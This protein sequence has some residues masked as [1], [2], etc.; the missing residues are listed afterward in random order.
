MAIDGIIGHTGFVGSCLTAHHRFAGQFN[1]RNISESADVAFE[2]VVCA[3]A[4]GSMFDANNTPERDHAQIMQLCDRLSAIKTKRFVLISSIAVLENFAG[5]DDE[6]THN[7]QKNLAYGRHRRMLE[8]FCDDH[9]KDVLILRLPA[10][11]GSGL[12][13]NFLFDLLNPVPTMF[14]STKMNDALNSVAARDTDVLRQVYRLNPENNMFVL[15]R[16]ALLNSGAQSR[17]TDALDQNSLNAV[18]FTHPETTF[19]FYGVDRLWQDIETARTNGLRVLHLATEPVHASVIHHRV[20]GR[21]M[22]NTNAPLHHEDMRS[23]YCGMWGQT[24][25]YLETADVVVPRVVSFC[26]KQREAA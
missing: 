15:D 13:K 18:Q 1:S 26:Q 19:Q 11:Y 3:A 12:K 7:F 16:A 17:I 25:P 22:P 24:G 23:M 2:T 6:T 8:A 9:F 21:S 5:K 10:L 20:L 4:P 14:N